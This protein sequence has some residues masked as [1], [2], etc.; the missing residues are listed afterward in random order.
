MATIK[1]IDFKLNQFQLRVPHLDLPDSGVTAIQGASGSG[2]TTFLN[3]FNWYS[4]AQRM[5]VA[6]RRC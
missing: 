2:K 4:S 3:Y 5:V 1:N 6:I